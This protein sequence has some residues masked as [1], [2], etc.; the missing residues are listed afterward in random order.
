MTVS[1]GKNFRY[2]IDYCK[3]FAKAEG[4]EIMDDSYIHIKSKMKF[5]HLSCRNVFDMDWEHFQR[6]QRCPLCSRELVHENQRLGIDFCRIESDKRGYTLLSN[7]YF[8]TE[9][10]MLFRHDE[11]EC[12]YEFEMS[13]NNFYNAGQNCPKCMN[14]VKLKIEDLKLKAMEKGYRLLSNKYVNSFTY[15][16]FEHLECGTVYEAVWNNFRCG[17]GCPFCNSSKGEIE[18]D[19]VLN[20]FGFKINEDYEREKS[21]DGLVYIYPLQVDF[22]LE[23]YETVIEFQGKQHFFPVDFAGKGSVWAEEQFKI[24]KIKDEIKRRYCKINNY[25]LIEI[26]YDEN[27]E[28]ILTKYFYK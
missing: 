7:K 2:T 15:M 14:H 16:T 8:N 11:N 25:N 17:K 9:F 24:N 13:W 22:W 28:E 21:F 3:N 4:F 1:T 26:I 27:V 6:G 23:E 18:V 12:G 5:V 19:R 20:S 10:K